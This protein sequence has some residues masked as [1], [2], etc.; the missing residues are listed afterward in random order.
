M[1]VFLVLSLLQLL[2]ASEVSG[3]EASLSPFEKMPNEILWMILSDLDIFNLRKLDVV[4]PYFHEIVKELESRYPRSRLPRTAQK[5][6]ITAISNNALASVDASLGNGWYNLDFNP[7]FV[8]CRD[9]YVLLRAI[10]LGNL[11]TVKRLIKHGAIV[12][13]DSLE[14]S[15]ISNKFETLIS[16]WSMQI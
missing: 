14:F 12:T 10:K 7:I 11:Q 6:L 1:L 13:F 2:R 8:G 4:S 16:C 3:E 9:K 15:F 5:E